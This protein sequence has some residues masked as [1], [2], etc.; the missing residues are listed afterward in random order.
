MAQMRLKAAE[1]V[2]SAAGARDLLQ[3]PLP[4]LA[5][6]GRSNVGK[7]TLI[8]RLVG[9]PLARTSAA[10]GK[11][12]L[13]NYFRLTPERGRAFHLVDLPGYGYARG[14][15]DGRAFAELTDERPR[16]NFNRLFERNIHGRQSS[17]HSGRA[18]VSPRPEA[19]A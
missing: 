9:R 8:N 5:I 1:F 12:R 4:E 3:T 14:A 6:A 15:K 11:T 7:S 16:M 18:P 2:T 19:F 13:A 17:C 10:P